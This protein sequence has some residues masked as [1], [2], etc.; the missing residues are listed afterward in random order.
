MKTLFLI[1][2]WASM[3]G[4]FATALM[5]IISKFKKNGRAKYYLYGLGVSVVL[6]FVAVANIE[7]AP[8]TPTT[9]TAA[10]GTQITAGETAISDEEQPEEHILSKAQLEVV[11]NFQKQDFEE[12]TKGYYRLTSEEQ[13]GYEKGIY[14]DYLHEK[15]VTWSGTVIKD[16]VW[17]SQII[18]YG[19]ADGYSGKTWEQ[20]DGTKEASQIFFARLI[21]KSAKDSIKPGDKV[22][23]K[24][25]IGINGEQ[26]KGDGNGINKRWKLYDAEV[27]TINGQTY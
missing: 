12:F 18:V 9:T 8:Q 6:F 16:G 22:K 13:T 17:S 26:E 2:F 10:Q 7:P 19:Y 23:F 15:E 5:A 21:D 11:N 3:L 20:I 4:F 1:L 27:L 24:G 25:I 14:L